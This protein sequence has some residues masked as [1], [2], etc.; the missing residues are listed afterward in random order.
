MPED[1]PESNLGISGP[2]LDD[3]DL[4]RELT[5]LKTKQHDIEADGTPDQKA[6]HVRRTAELESEFVARFG[7]DARGEAASHD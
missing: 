2:S 1:A 3:A 5:S 7:A 6:N 4:L